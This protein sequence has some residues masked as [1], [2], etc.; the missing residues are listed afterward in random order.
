MSPAYSSSDVSQSTSYGTST[1]NNTNNNG[2]GSGY[3]RGLNQCYQNNY[4]SNGGYYGHGGNYAFSFGTMTQEFSGQD[5]FLFFTVIWGAFVLIYFGCWIRRKAKLE[6]L[7][8]C[9][10]SIC[11][12]KIRF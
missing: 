10:F 5:G 8:L 2:D 11:G 3:Q 6:F 12:L 1:Y 7:A 9:G 4:E